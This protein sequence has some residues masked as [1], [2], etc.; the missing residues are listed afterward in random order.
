MIRQ[1]TNPST[2]SIHHEHDPAPRRVEHP[3]KRADSHQPSSLNEGHPCACQ[4]GRRTGLQDFPG[5]D[6]CS[7]K[8]PACPPP[9]VSSGRVCCVLTATASFLSRVRKCAFRPVLKKRVIWIRRAQRHQWQGEFAACYL[10]IPG[11]HTT[12]PMGPLHRPGNVTRCL[13]VGI[14]GESGRALRLPLPGFPFS[15]A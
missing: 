15:H 10:E 3:Q 6:R 9:R 12:Q 11:Q 1:Q 4:K 13:R 8:P 14:E 2:I 7:P 5:H